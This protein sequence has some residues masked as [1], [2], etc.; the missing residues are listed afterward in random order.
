[1]G[2]DRFEAFKLIHKETDIWVGVDRSSYREEMVDFLRKE[3]V[4][5]RKVME[6]YIASHPEFRD[7]LEPVKPKGKA[8]LIVKDMWEA[9]EKA[10]VGPMAAVAGAFAQHLGFRILEEFDVEEVIVENGGDV[11]LKLVQP[12]VV[13]IFAGRSPLSGKVGLEINPEDTPCGVC[14]SSATVGPSLS[15][16][17]ADAVTVVCEKAALAD[18]FATAYCNRIKSRADI[19]RIVTDVQ[20]VPEI[21]TLVA[22]MEDVMGVWGKHHL[23]ILKG[24]G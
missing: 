5:L 7:S 23:R 4:R 16:G 10:G 11:F 15:L 8:P 6:E 19:E 3:V 20:G 17:R 18:A 22:V 2:R 1:M 24:S 9:G 12:A 13:A 21:L 14:T